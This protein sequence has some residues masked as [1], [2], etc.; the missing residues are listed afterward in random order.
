M[1][2][3]DH[4]QGEYH[5]GRKFD[6]M[7]KFV[8]DRLG[9]DCYIHNLHE[10]CTEDDKDHLRYYSRLNHEERDAHVEE[11]KQMERENKK[12]RRSGRQVPHDEKELH[13]KR[14][15]VRELHAHE[16]VMDIMNTR[17]AKLPKL[18]KIP[19]AEKVEL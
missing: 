1:Y 5:L 8:H 19:D 7:K 15:N 3:M 12:A 10:S 4:T 16:L 2:F 9:V 13:R 6:D 17:P 11:L 14:H 18:E